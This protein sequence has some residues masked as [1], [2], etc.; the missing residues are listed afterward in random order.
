LLQGDEKLVQLMVG[1]DGLLIQ[2][3]HTLFKDGL[4]LLK[5]VERQKR[6]VNLI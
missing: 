2:E 4:L 5:V 1:V 6:L 3:L